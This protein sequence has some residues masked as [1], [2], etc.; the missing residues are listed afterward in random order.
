MKL[1]VIE[2]QADCVYRCPDDDL[3]DAYGSI[4][5]AEEY[6][7]GG[8]GEKRSCTIVEYGPVPKE[9]PLTHAGENCWCSP[10]VE[11]YCGRK[12]VIHNE[13]Q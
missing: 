4:E 9:K 3:Q 8:C 12:I 10:R 7:R 1:F 2:H 6:K 13:E 5:R 11:D